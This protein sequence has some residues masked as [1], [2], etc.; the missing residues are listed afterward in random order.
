MARIVES[1][2]CLRQP[3]YRQSQVYG[4]AGVPL[5]RSLR[6]QWVRAGHELVSLLV[7]AVRRHVLAIG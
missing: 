3:L 1:K 2:F 7:Q 5:K 4:F 6:A